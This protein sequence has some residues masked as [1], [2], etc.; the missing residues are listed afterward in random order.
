MNVRATCLLLCVFVNYVVESLK[1]ESGPQHDRVV[2][3]YVS[4]WATY[5]KGRGQFTIDDIDPRLCTHLVYAFAGLNASSSSIQSL[6]PYNDLEE[7]YGKG[8]YKKMAGLMKRY[9]H[10]TVT[11]AIGG[12]NEGSA[13]YSA[14]A[15]DPAKR[16]IFIDSVIKFLKKHNFHGLDLDWEFPGKRGGIPEDKENFVLLVQELREALYPHKFILTAALGA[17][18]DT[19]EVGYDLR[20]L[21]KYLDYFHLMCYDYHGKWD[22]K[23][24]ANAPLTSSD[25]NDYFTVEYSVNYMLSHGVDAN[26]LVLGLP[27][28]GR[29]FKLLDENE[30]S[31]NLGAA[32]A[33]TAFSGPYTNEDGFMG[34]NEVCMEITNLNSSW[35]EHWDENSQTPFAKNGVKVV[36]FDNQR[37]IT[38]KVKFAMHKDLGGVMFWSI[39]TDDFRGDCVTEENQDKEAFLLL[40]S[41]NRAIITTLQEIQITKEKEKELDTNENNN[42]DNEG[43]PDSSS[44]HRLTYAVLF[45]TILICVMY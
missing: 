37:S 30:N 4:T 19:M 40:Q 16:K 43:N 2:V 9:P 41:A 42:I 45:I 11:V 35:T 17:G 26:K 13:N 38:E 14:L 21:N 3:C 7:D 44:R 31:D 27:T 36:S 1:T 5:R 20:Q 33:E 25:K 28:Y 15:A 32:T 18:K 22:K 10:L 23:T 34:Y 12:W 29:T 8:S 6:D 24:G 39:D